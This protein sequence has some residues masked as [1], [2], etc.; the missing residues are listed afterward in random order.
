LNS[1]KN[2][3]ALGLLVV[4]SKAISTTSIDGIVPIPPVSPHAKAT[5]VSDAIAS[6]RVKVADH[7]SP[8][9]PASAETESDVPHPETSVM[10]FSVPVREPPLIS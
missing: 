2:D 4:Y 1:R 9:P 7:K 10:C 5:P 6:V 3:D 8:V